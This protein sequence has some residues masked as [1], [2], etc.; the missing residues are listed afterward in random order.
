MIPVSM[1]QVKVNNTNINNTGDVCL[2]IF[3][4]YIIF[5]I[6]LFSFLLG[7]Q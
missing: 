3:G 6:A 4:M 5:F 2:V 7:M 1:L